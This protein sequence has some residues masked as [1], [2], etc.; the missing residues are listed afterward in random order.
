MDSS[1]TITPGARV[2]AKVDGTLIEVRVREVSPSGRYVQVDQVPSPE[3]SRC[4]WGPRDA[5]VEVLDA[6]AE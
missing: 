5:I 1:T 2:L 3:G 6:D 4:L